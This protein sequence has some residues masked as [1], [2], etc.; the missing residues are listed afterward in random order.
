MFNI[1]CREDLSLTEIR[2][3]YDRASVTDYN[4]WEA[5]GN[6]GWGWDGLLPYFKKGTEYIPPPAALVKEYSVTWDPEA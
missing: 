1:A 6:Q 2:K 3:M 4:A 5:L